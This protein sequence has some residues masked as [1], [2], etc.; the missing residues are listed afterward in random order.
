MAKISLTN[1]STIRHFW[2]RLLHKLY[3]NVAIS[4]NLSLHKGFCNVQKLK[5]L[6][7]V[8]MNITQMG[9]AKREISPV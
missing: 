3:I 9:G 2:H 4:V 6:S 5:L 1:K 7:I 8:Y